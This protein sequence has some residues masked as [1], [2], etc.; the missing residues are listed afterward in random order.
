MHALKQ[1]LD[2]N[3]SAGIWTG[4]S[5]VLPASDEETVE[6]TECPANRNDSHIGNRESRSHLQ[7]FEY[8]Q[9][10]ANPI[11]ETQ[12]IESS[13]LFM[14][15]LAGT[16]TIYGSR[17][18]FALSVVW[19]LI[20][21]SLCIFCGTDSPKYWKLNNELSY[22][23]V[24]AEYGIVA[25][26]VYH[27]FLSYI[28]RYRLKS[29]GILCYDANVWPFLKTYCT[30]CVCAA[31]MPVG[32]YIMGTK[33]HVDFQVVGVF[34]LFSIQCIPYIAIACMLRAELKSLSDMTSACIHAESDIKARYAA[35][36]NAIQK[37][38]SRWAGP[39][40]IHFIVEFWVVAA[41]ALQNYFFWPCNW[42]R[43]GV[44]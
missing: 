38:S 28:M 35:V 30:V 24:A 10:T 1:R 17:P 34:A 37:V 14:L 4:K 44:V 11:S 40:I 29:S 39:L 7:P 19:C 18:W 8:S 26:F 3:I 31:C 25:S 12:E 9:F 22:A 41:Q 16:E 13:T 42:W 23:Y 27:F 36:H 5:F 43:Y 15:R 32:S 2:Q 6:L 21:L 20:L 33:G